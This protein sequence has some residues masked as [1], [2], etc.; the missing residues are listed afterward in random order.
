MRGLVTALLAMYASGGIFSAM[1]NDPARAHSGKTTAK[2]TI[3][4]TV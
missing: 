2:T 3:A 1:G 4:K